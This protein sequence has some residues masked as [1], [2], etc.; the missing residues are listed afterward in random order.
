ME[1]RKGKNEAPVSHSI[2]NLREEEEDK[3]GKEGI[4]RKE[5]SNH[6]TNKPKPS[7]G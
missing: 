1:G 7:F 5:P 3:E 4:K 6:L 2:T